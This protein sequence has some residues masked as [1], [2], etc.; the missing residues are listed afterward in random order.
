MTASRKLLALGAA[1][2]AATTGAALAVRTVGRQIAATTDERIDPLLVAPEGVT[3]HRIPSYDGGTLHVAERGSGPPVVLLHGV[4]LQWNIWSPLLRLLGEDHRVLA[5]DMR[6]HGESVSGEEGVTLR[7]IAT[8]LV[9]VLGELDVQDA[10]VVGHSMGGM[11]LQRFLIDHDTTAQRRVR[12]AV[13]LATSAAP[14]EL[15]RPLPAS[16]ALPLIATALSGP[17]R[18]RFA[19]GNLSRVLLRRPFGRL[20]TAAAVEQLR[21]M[22]SEVSAKTLSEAVWTIADHD[23]RTS[24]AGNQVP[25]SVVTG[26]LDRLTPPSHARTLAEAL[27]G[28]DLHLLDGIGHQVMQEDP[29]GLAEILAPMCATAD[30]VG[31]QHP[32]QGNGAARRVNEE[33]S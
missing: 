33:L 5:W 10:V 31:M 23:T 15:V 1:T 3:H 6:G 21:S 2:A 30:A 16:A 13:L 26:R 29:Y 17:R 27:G 24:L 22:V 20:A 8:D 19:P 11:A 25:A 12:R 32:H 14:A 4:T 9:T 28:A 7:A 18:Y